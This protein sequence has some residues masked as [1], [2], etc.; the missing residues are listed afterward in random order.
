MNLTGEERRRILAGDHAALKREADPG[1]VE[2]QMVPLLRRQ[3]HVVPIYEDAKFSGHVR[4][5]V[6]AQ[7]VPEHWSV[8]IELGK[9]RRHRRGHWL[10]PFA[11]HDERQSSRVLR[12]GGPPGAPREAGLKTRLTPPEEVR[13]RGEGITPY[14]EETAR[15]YGGAGRHALDYGGL[16]DPELEEMARANRERWEEF[17]AQERADEC[18]AQDARRLAIKLEKTQKKAARMGVDIA[19]VL[20]RALEDAQEA[21]REEAA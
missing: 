21:I 9:P 10:I 5:V 4:E 14:T 8:R 20:L 12:A 18:Q 15:G 19:P 16:S 3:A 2:G 7:E 6:G 17:M 11:V 13:P 1:D